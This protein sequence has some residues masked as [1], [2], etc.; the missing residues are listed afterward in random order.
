M[1]M[2]MNIMM[3]NNMINIEHEYIC[4]QYN[5]IYTKRFWNFTIY[6]ISNFSQNLTR[7]KYDDYDYGVDGF[8]GM[9]F[10]TG[11]HVSF[12]QLGPSQ[13]SWS[14]SHDVRMYVCL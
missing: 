6:N 13:P 14:V 4:C 3:M 12:H 8:N 9:A 10:M 5:L 7:Y 1:M 2:M 11:L